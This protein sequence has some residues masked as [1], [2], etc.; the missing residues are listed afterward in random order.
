MGESKRKKIYPAAACRAGGIHV[1]V[2]A[3]D[4]AARIEKCHEAIPDVRVHSSYGAVKA[5]DDGA[6]SSTAVAA[7]TAEQQLKLAD[8]IYQWTDETEWGELYAAIDPNSE[9]QGSEMYTAVMNR[10]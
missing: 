8:L 4:I 5:E 6:S 2:R 10:Y 1:W 7:G 3:V 9:T